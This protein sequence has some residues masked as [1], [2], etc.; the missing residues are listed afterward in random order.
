MALR[1]GLARWAGIAGAERETTDDSAPLGISRDG[2]L[3]KSGDETSDQ[4]GA[5]MEQ[6][7]DTN[8]R[9]TTSVTG[10]E[11]VIVRDT[12][13]GTGTEIGAMIGTG[14]GA[15]MDTGARIGGAMK[16]VGAGV[17]TGGTERGRGRVMEGMREE[18]IMIG[19]EKQIGIGA[20]TDAGDMIEHGVGALVARQCIRLHSYRRRCCTSTI[21]MINLE[22]VDS[23]G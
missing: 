14:G 3:A 19:E 7:R 11:I 13:R 12:T 21:G 20:T 4:R 5:A 8:E 23:L 18:A 2:I 6:R 17:Q 15:R 10:T 9:R 16:G 22:E 1:S